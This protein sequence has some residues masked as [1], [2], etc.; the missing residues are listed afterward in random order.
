MVNAA[1]AVIG[2]EVRVDAEVVK[3]PGVYVDENGKDFYD[4]VVGLAH[5]CEEQCNAPSS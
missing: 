5:Q 4:R 2:V 3:Y 1:K